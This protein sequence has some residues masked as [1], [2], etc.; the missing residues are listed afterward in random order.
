MLKALALMK[1]VSAE[2]V[3]VGDEVKD[4]QAARA[5]KIPTIAALWGA[6][7]RG[8]VVNEKPDYMAESVSELSELLMAWV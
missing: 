7:D 5:A 3:S 2:T 8:A 4:I 6:A 1:T